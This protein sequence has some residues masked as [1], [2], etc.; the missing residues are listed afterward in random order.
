VAGSVAASLMAREND[1]R[2]NMRRN[3]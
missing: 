1:E 2:A 3:G